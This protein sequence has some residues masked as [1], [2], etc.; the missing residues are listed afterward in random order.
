MIHAGLVGVIRSRLNAVGI[1]DLA[2]V[3]EARG[4]SSAG[5]TMH[6][7]VVVHDF[8]AEGRHLVIDS[9]VTTVYQNIILQQV[10]SIPAE[11]SKFYANG[12]YTQPS[13]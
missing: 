13:L 5:A 6:G 7:D 10:A 4:L 3:T 1:P 9:V 8:C 2:I 12:A 11:D